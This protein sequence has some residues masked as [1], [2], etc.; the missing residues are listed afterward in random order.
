VSA[1]D[2]EVVELSC[3]ELMEEEAND[4]DEEEIL[5]GDNVKGASE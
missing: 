2:E 1:I 5:W 4:D 3:E